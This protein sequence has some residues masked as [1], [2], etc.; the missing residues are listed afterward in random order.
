MIHRVPAYLRQ[1]QGY[2]PIEPIDVLA[3][4][5]GLPEEQIAKLDGNE[6]PYGPSPKVIKALCD[7]RY[8]HIY[9]DPEQREV[10]EAIGKHIGLVPQH[11]VAGSGAD[12]LLDIIGRMFIASG[13]PVVSAPPTFGMYSFIAGLYGT[14]FAFLP[15]ADWHF[16]FYAMLASLGVLA[17]GM[18]YHFR[19]KKWI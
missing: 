4:E 14:N 18:L 8:Y 16:G 1:M 15:G 2:E 10:R 11:I 9:S 6:N 7:F 19:R 12:E 5:L 13:T 17:A 3:R